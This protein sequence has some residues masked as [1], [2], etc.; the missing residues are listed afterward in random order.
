MGE[1]TSAIRILAV[2]DH[3]SF[4]SG[5]AMLLSTQPDMTLIAEAFNGLDAIEKYRNFRPDI[6]LMDLQ[7]PV[8][9]GL[10]A[11]NAI[12]EE[13]PDARIIVLTTYVGDVRMVRALEAGARACLI[14]GLLHKE[15]LQTI[16]SVHLEK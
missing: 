7:M 9:N 2:D 16:R 11:L 4:R 6:T 5:L 10:D 14:K 1:E 12:R 3:P 8:M 13:F 15:L